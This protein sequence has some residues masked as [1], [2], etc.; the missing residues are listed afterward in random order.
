MSR[1]PLT[2][3]QT[4]LE[5]RPVLTKSVTAGVITAIGD[6]LAQDLERRA[7]LAAAARAAAVGSS[8]LVVASPSSLLDLQRLFAFT[9]AGSFF[10]GPFVHYWYELLWS[11][12]RR[13]TLRSKTTPQTAITLLLVFLDQT[14]G[15]CLFFPPYIFAYEFFST[16]AS[17]VLPLLV[18]LSLAASALSSSGASLPLSSFIGKSQARIRTSLLSILIANWYVW[19]FINFVSFSF[20]PEIYRGLFSNIASVFWNVY[21]CNKMGKK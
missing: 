6:V 15:A 20:V 4:L 3:Y 11:I 21:L 1:N 9:L 12:R 8:A 2:A 14:I 5:R 19:P 10:V 13:L 16:A 18:P 17:Q 7:A